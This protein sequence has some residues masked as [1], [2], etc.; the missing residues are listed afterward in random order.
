MFTV[1]ALALDAALPS[2][3][4]FGSLLSVSVVLAAL[5]YPVAAVTGTG[6]AG[7]AALLCLEVLEGGPAAH[8]I[9]TLITLAVVTLFG[10]LLAAVRVHALARLTRVETVAEVVQLAL[11]RPLPTRS[12]PLR[13]AG[14][15]RGADDEA[16]IGGDLYSV[17]ATRFGVRALVGDVKGKGIAA[18]ETVAT[19]VSAFREAA[20]FAPDLQVVAERIES[21]MALDRADAAAGTSSPSGK[22]KAV[23]TVAAMRKTEETDEL[24]T[25]AVLMEFARDG[26]AVRVLNRGHPPPL[27][28]G[29]YGASALETEYSV[30]LGFGDLA[31]AGSDVHHF[32]LN[33][34]ELLLAYSDGVTEARDEHGDFYP[35]AARLTARFC[36]SATRLVPADV[37]SFLQDDVA[38]WAAGLNDDM[39]AVVLQPDPQGATVTPPSRAPAPPQ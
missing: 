38:S 30:P 27:R 14:F 6:V 28:L 4:S 8:A 5:V 11:L 26:S 37:V 39:V 35:L 10:T 12:G 32:T 2:T 17:R 23:A 29:P 3:F 34:D 13:V 33:P 19:V 15:Y 9:G 24:F 25:T 7:M 18:T 36:G 20:M 21:A 31:P 16:L 1:V 22:R